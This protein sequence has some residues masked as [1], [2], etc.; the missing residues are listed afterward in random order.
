MQILLSKSLRR[1]S[2]LYGRAIVKVL[3]DLHLEH[4]AEIILLLA[5]TDHTP[6]HKELA[7]LLQIDKSRIAVVINGMTQNGFVYTERNSADRRAHLVYL[8]CKGKESVPKIQEAIEQVNKLIN[9]QLDKAQLDQFYATLSKMQSNLFEINALK[10]NS[11]KVRVKLL[12]QTRN[13]LSDDINNIS[14]HAVRVIDCH[15]YNQ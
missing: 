14:G 9:K 12:R 1:L 5:D 8:T 6:T 7:E 10:N 3:P 2:R 13:A 11:K 15:V 4:Y